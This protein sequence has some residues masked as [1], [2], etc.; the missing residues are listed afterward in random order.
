VCVCVFGGGVFIE[1]DEGRDGTLW[2]IT[3]SESGL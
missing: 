3:D 2:T 1:P